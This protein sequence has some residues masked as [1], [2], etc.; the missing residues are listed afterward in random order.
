MGR[1]NHPSRVTWGKPTSRANPPPNSAHMRL[2][3]IPDPAASATAAYASL[4]A[5]LGRPAWCPTYHVRA[6]NLDHQ[7]CEKACEQSLA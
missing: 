6:C 4:K 2:F 5:N 7:R 1:T 3:I